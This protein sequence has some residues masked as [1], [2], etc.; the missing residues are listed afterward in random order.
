M[1]R[2]IDLTGQKFGRLTVLRRTGTDK[3]SNVLWLCVCDCGNKKIV[4]S[5]HLR[6]GQ[7]LSCGC[8]LK[9]RMQDLGRKNTK[10]G[11]CGT[12][13][14][15]IYNNMIVRCFN[16]NARSY[17]DYGGRGITVCDKWSH[18]FQAFYDWAMANGYAD[19]LTL[20]RIDV[21][22]NYEPLNCRWATKKEQ[23]NNTRRNRMITYN[24][25]T[26][27]IKQWADEYGINYPKLKDRIN[28]LHWTIERALNTP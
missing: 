9:E 4:S 25:K 17:Q 13:I 15:R 14:Y 10:H 22:G 24:N 27:T 1:S 6:M 28:K 12:R 23:A 20:D 26:Q 11:C 7:C 18:N 3:H 16:Q 2:F 21:N 19:N 8:L 5:N